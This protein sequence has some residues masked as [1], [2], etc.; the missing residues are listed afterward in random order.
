MLHSF[1]LFSSG[2]LFDKQRNMAII[3]VSCVVGVVLIIAIVSLISIRRK[4]IEDKAKAKIENDLEETMELGKIDISLFYSDDNLC[5]DGEEVNETD[6][7]VAVSSEI[8]LNNE[9]QGNEVAAVVQLKSEMAINE[10]NEDAEGEELA[11]V[12]ENVPPEIDVVSSCQFGVMEEDESLVKEAEI[13]LQTNDA[14]C[15]PEQA[16]ISEVVD[17]MEEPCGKHPEAEGN[18]KEELAPSIGYTSVPDD[19][20]NTDDTLCYANAAVNP[21]YE[22]NE[23]CEE[24][25]AVYAN[26]PV[27]AGNQETK[28]NVTEEPFYANVDGL[29]FEQNER[30]Q[31]SLYTNLQGNDVHEETEANYAKEPCYANVCSLGHPDEDPGEVP[32]DQGFFPNGCSNLGYEDS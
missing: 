28:A 31:E 10:V 19:D 27:T 17:A 29:N 20:G 14:E 16:A 1:I 30:S 13:V 7:N 26:M 4:K 12:A 32:S 23:A 11:V 24:S 2:Q 8:L 6:V 5:Q 15:A 22:Y 18:S 3:G 21:S 25:M 9:Y